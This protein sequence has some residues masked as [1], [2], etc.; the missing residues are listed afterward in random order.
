MYLPPF[1][2]DVGLICGVDAA[3]TGRVEDIVL[4]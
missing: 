4:D 1:V 2:C 3:D